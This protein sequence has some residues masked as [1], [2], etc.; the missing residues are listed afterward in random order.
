MTHDRERRG[1]QLLPMTNLATLLVPVAFM[2]AQAIA[3]SWMSP[4]G[5]VGIENPGDERVRP[6]DLIVEVQSDGLRI[7]GAEEVLA[8][9]EGRPFLPCDAGCGPGTYD[10]EGLNRLLGH[11][12]NAY[13]WVEAIEVRADPGIDYPAIVQVLDAAAER[14]GE[15]LFPRVRLGTL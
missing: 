10:T 9:P 12:K 3:L 8:G 14:E 15:E 2:G 5:P 1:W 13:P 6:V 11:V 7:L 4:D